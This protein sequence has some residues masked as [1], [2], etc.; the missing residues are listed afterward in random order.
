MNQQFARFDQ[1][2]R[3]HDINID[4]KNNKNF[5]QTN[6]FENRLHEKHFFFQIL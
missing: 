3:R 4:I 1:I 6:V 2:I 5:F